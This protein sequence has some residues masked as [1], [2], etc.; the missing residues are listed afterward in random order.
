MVSFWVHWLWSALSLWFQCWISSRLCSRTDRLNVIWSCCCWRRDRSG[1]RSEWFP[2]EPASFLQPQIKGEKRL[3]GGTNL[4]GCS[5]DR[6][7]IPLVQMQ[8]FPV[9][10]ETLPLGNNTTVAW[11]TTPPVPAHCLDPPGLQQVLPCTLTGMAG[12][13]GL[14]QHSR[15]AL[16]LCLLW[17]LI[18]EGQMPTEKAKLT[19]VQPYTSIHC[20]HYPEAGVN[21]LSPTCFSLIFFSFRKVEFSKKQM[22]VVLVNT[23]VVSL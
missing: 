9:C 5:S 12:C 19:W 13:H 1:I 15:V 6:L 20:Y 18:Q 7:L 21:R 11:A 14:W 3:P 22:Y 4:T 8:T 17:K 2:G 16:D 23:V 10:L